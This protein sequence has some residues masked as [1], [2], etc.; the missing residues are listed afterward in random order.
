M[1]TF[2]MGTIESMI[3]FQRKRE[4]VIAVQSREKPH[5]CLSLK[6]ASSGWCDQNLKFLKLYS[7]NSVG[8]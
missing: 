4:D 2:F 7:E 3:S 5:H 8:C 6:A 1:S